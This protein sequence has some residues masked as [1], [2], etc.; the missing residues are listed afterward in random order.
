M[1]RGYVLVGIML[2]LSL[3]IAE[4]RLPQIGDTVQIF[5]DNGINSL[6]YW[7]SVTDISDGLIGLKCFYKYA[8]WSTQNIGQEDTTIQN[9]TIGIGSIRAIYWVNSTNDLVL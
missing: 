9:V 8:E 1:I 6:V 7:G 5:T 3:G 2:I 4:A